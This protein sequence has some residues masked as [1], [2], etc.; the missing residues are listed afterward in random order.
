MEEGCDGEMEFSWRG[1]GVRGWLDRWVREDFGGE[2]EFSDR[3][4]HCQM[5]LRGTLSFE[6]N[7]TGRGNPR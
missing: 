6:V 4:E 5:A 1:G 2:M 3:G 7:F